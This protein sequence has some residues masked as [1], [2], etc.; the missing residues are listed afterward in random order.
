MQ[1]IGI[2]GSIWKAKQGILALALLGLVELLIIDVSATALKINIMGAGIFIIA[3]PIVGLLSAAV[4]CWEAAKLLHE[5]KNGPSSMAFSGALTAFCASLF[6]VFAMLALSILGFGVA[7]FF[8]SG[9]GWTLN[10]FAVHA[11]LIFTVPLSYAIF[12]AMLGAITSLA[13]RKK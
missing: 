2:S 1:S 10:R 5:G 4:I 11:L 6:V 13:L 12:G 3:S 9:S 7:K 8:Q